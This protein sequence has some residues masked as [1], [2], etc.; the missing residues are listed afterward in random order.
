[1]TKFLTKFGHDQNPYQI[2]SW[3]NSLPNLVMTKFITKLGHDQNPYQI[4]PWPNSAMTKFLTKIG[5]DQTP[6]QI[7]S[8]PK[9]LPHLVMT[10]ILTK[11]GPDRPLGERFRGWP[12]WFRGWRRVT[13]IWVISR[14]WGHT[15][16]I[17]F[18]ATFRLQ[19]SMYVGS[20]FDR[21]TDRPTDRPWKFHVTLLS[22]SMS[23]RWKDIEDI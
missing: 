13:S 2:W 22:R 19:L 6:Y 12:N 20:N 5:H 1:M 10:K 3:P 11:V 18:I 16:K 15:F 14:G 4:R 7:W 17:V 21:P 9:S 23:R 8:W